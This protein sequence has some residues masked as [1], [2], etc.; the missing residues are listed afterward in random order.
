MNYTRYILNVEYLY[1]CLCIVFF[2][3]LITNLIR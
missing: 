2:F 3:M 1:I